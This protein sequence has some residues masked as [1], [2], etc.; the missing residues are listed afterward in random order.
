[1]RPTN[2]FRWIRRMEATFHSFP[3]SLILIAALVRDQGTSGEFLLIIVTMILLL[4][5]TISTIIEDDKW[6]FGIDS[7]F[8]KLCP[9]HPKYLF[10]STFRLCEV[11]SRVIT[12]SLVW[13]ATTGY[14]LMVC[15]IYQMVFYSLLYKRGKLGRDPGH[16]LSIVF[17][18]PNLSY[19]DTDYTQM[20]L[21]L[22]LIGV[23]T[24][25]TIYAYL[26]KN[27]NNQ[28]IFY[29]ARC[30]ENFILLVVVLCLIMF[31]RTHPHLL[32]YPLDISIM[33]FAVAIFCNFYVAILYFTKIRKYLD[34]MENTISLDI[35][36]ILKSSTED[37][38]IL[39]RFITR[40][41]TSIHKVRE[42]GITTVM[43]TAKHSNCNV[44]LCILHGDVYFNE[45]DIVFARMNPLQLF[46]YNKS[47]K[48]LAADNR[49]INK[50]SPPNVYSQDE[51]GR[52]C[53]YYLIEQFRKNKKHYGDQPWK[54][55]YEFKQRRDW[56]LM[57]TQHAK[58][59]PSSQSQHIQDEMKEDALFSTENTPLILINKLPKS[60]NE[61]LLINMSDNYDRTPLHWATNLDCVDFVKTL[62]ELGANPNICDKHYNE[63]PMHLA[64]RKDR[65]EIFDAFII[66]N[67][68]VN[69]VIT[70]P[71]ENTIEYILC[72]WY[73]NNKMGDDVIFAC[74]NYNRPDLLTH[75]FTAYVEVTR[76]DEHKN[77]I[78]Q[79]SIISQKEDCIKEILKRDMLSIDL[80][81][82]KNIYLNSAL[83]MAVLEQNIQIVG[84]LTH[85]LLIK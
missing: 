65:Y 21:L 33:S 53:I 14:Y 83:E 80:L 82:N 61:S 2:H 54:Q 20:N 77:T 11:C 74:I 62:L 57:L 28:C 50:W 12:L 67:S 5:S 31:A 32:Q 49:N 45:T 52:T 6:K 84:M 1:M 46:K 34:F 51:Q 78:L 19:N 58:E 69:G 4:W 29:A 18:Y 64:V 24:G 3:S 59:H 16:V 40:T 81:V 71:N 73:I 56:L 38:D 36:R 35:W 30:T 26:F 25:W 68:K 44:L 42:D 39:R 66:W 23:F 41:P 27:W 7:P 85:H 37:I 15:G 43:E 8:R 60:Q 76:L 10:R 9:P 79:F 17:A 72:N 70:Y 13:D 63:T 22:K 55:K 47:Q 48:Q 75:L